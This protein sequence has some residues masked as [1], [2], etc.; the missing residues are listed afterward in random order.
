[1]KSKFEIAQPWF[2]EI[3]TCIK[4]D[5]KTDYLPADKIFY[6]A[7]FGNRP[8]N[9]LSTEEIFAAFEKELLTGNEGLEEWVVNHW[10]F[11]H[12]DIYRHLAD[13]L[14][15]INPNFTD[16]EE[17][18]SEESKTV[19]EGTDAFNPVDL[20]LF[21]ILN[22][23]VFPETVLETLRNGAIEGKAKADEA[24]AMLAKKEGLEQIIERQQREISRLQE[25][26]ESKVEGVLR[27]YTTDME[28]LKRQIRS[29]QQQLNR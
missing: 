3:L 28:A 16:L 24:E 12:G 18:S 27:K 13:R 10:V 25:K 1:M 7:H 15:A 21:S 6:R 14:S 9:R 23:V 4:K 26:C 19:L 2:K 20:Y 5:L 29:L 22:G 8:L 11:Q 17:I